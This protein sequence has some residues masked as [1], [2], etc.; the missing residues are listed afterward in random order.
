MRQRLGDTPSSARKGG[1]K[2]QGAR[3]SSSQGPRWRPRGGRDEGAGLEMQVQGE[4]MV[5]R[6]KVEP[7]RE[8]RGNERGRPRSLRGRGDGT[9]AGRGGP[10]EDVRSGFHTVCSSFS[11]AFLV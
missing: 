4:V 8:G 3:V 10:V 5:A 11:L 6:T 2:R 9:G 7:R 1:V